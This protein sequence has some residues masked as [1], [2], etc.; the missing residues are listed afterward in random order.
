MDDNNNENRFMKTNALAVRILLACCLLTLAQAAF[1]FKPFVVKD[2]RVEGLQ[3][4]TPGTVFNYLPVK[5]G[6]TFTEETSIESVRALFKTGFF[7]DVK[8]ERDGNVLVVVVKE[9]PAIGS[10]S[11]SGNKD[12]K[13]DK[14]MDG[15]KQI[16]IAEGR[17]FDQSQLDKLEQELKRQY[18]SAGKYGVSIKST[19][20]PLDNNR[21]GIDIK[22]SE[23]RAARIK[24][25]NI[26]GNHAFTDKQLLSVFELT[27]PTMLSFFT[28]SDQYSREKLSGD[29]ERLRS[30]Y[31]DRGY[32][33]FS[34]DSTQ[35]SITPDKKDIY[36]TINITE[37]SQYKVSDIKLA[38]DFIVPAKQLFKLISIKQG[39]LFSRK[40]A[41]A[42]S[43]RITDL[44]GSKGYAFANVNTIPNID[45]KNKT[46]A[47]T[48]F[49]DPGKKVYVRHINFSGNTR[50]RDVV[51]RREMRQQESGWIS[52]PKVDRGKVRLQRLGF[53]KSV[54]VETPAVP[55]TADRVDVNYT[56]EEKPFG[57][58]MAGVGYSQTS[59][60]IFQT[61]VTQSNFL[62]SGKQIQFAFNNSRINR[63]YSLGY[64]NPYYTIDGISRGFNVSYQDTYAYSANLTAYNNRT[65]GGGVNFGVPISEYN[66]IYTSLN[67]ENTKI[68]ASSIS[69]SQEVQNFL[70][71][72]GNDFNIVRLNA[73]FRYD[74][75]NKAIL[76]DKG[77]YDEIGGEVGLPTF[78]KHS[79]EYYK[80]Y[81]RAQW[82]HPVWRNFVISA[83]GELG[84]GNGWLGTNQL[85]FFENFY[86]GGPHSVRGFQEN[87]LGPRDSSGLP[88][89]GNIETVGSAEL[90]LPVP[91]IKAIK[92]SVRISTFID[93][94][95]VYGTGERFSL[96][97]LRYSVGVSGIW[98][99]PFG[100]VSVSVADPI[101]KQPG[102]KTQMFQFS[103][104]TQF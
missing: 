6:D 11:I 58:F 89:G 35:V 8:M 42:S 55:G 73:S 26:V 86:A 104:G 70:S 45:Q 4:L 57:N 19:V 46:V 68:S 63:Q 78:F 1:A 81:Y 32:I 60:L 49:V 12:I 43:K 102:D 99:S 37:G 56:V 10:I 64:L 34:I 54:N 20:T 38:G 47:I 76:P 87:T 17:V 72:Y 65:Y 36:I 39:K 2:I 15:L 14:L 18:Y 51:L 28:K 29:L 31:L 59:G 52:T 62:G 74:T 40:E 53:F 67:Y 9:R 92:D 7:N 23:G 3:R 79:L 71:Q 61:S 88:L 16:G 48:F 24:Q 41:T 33:N 98:V 91:F 100:L 22:I 5:V 77:V 95:N 50:T 27:T 44:L 83:R 69:Y 13:T 84:Y 66:S 25:I 82:Y 97:K 96:S 103:F 94:G 85:P 93:A 21:V 75:R 30:Y 101:G 80:V 90:I